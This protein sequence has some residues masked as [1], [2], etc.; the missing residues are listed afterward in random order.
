MVNIK[1]MMIVE[2]AFCPGGRNCPTQIRIQWR[3]EREEVD[4]AQSGN[5]TQI[6]MFDAS[7]GEIPCLECCV[8]TFS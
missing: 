2:R 6:P 1:M 5:F 4:A 8:L 3:M 7:K